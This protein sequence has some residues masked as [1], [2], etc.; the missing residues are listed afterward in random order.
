MG[1]AGAGYVKIW[2]LGCI[3]GAR[4]WCESEKV[5]GTTSSFDHGVMKGLREW[6]KCGDYVQA[7]RRGGYEWG[8]LRLE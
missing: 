4:R 6:D 3:L 2:R 1:A 7:E 8:R 5:S